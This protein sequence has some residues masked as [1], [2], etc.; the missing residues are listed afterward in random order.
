M[1]TQKNS[2]LLSAIKM[3]E[4]TLIDAMIFQEILAGID[5]NIPTLAFSTSQ[6][7]VKNSLSTVWAKILVDDYVP[8]FKIALDLLTVIPSSPGVEEA[9]KTLAVEAQKIAS[10]RALLRHDLMG[11]I[12]HRLLMSDIAKFYATYYTSVP[13][14]YLLA[15]FALDAPNDYWQF[16]WANLDSVANF[17]VAD[18]ACGSGTLL[19]AAYSAILDKYVIT[20]AGEDFE[21]DPKKLHRILIE[22][23]LLGLDVLSFAAHLSAVTLA[24]H[25]PSSEFGNTQIYAL[26]QTGKADKPRLG[27]IDL[28]ESSEITP[29]YL[30]S[31]SGIIGKV[32]SPEQ[33]GITQSGSLSIK[34]EPQN[35]ITMNPPFTRSVIGNKLFGALPANERKK[36]QSH[37][38]KLLKQKGFSGIGQAGLAAVFV[39]IGDKYLQQGGR[40]AF[41][42]P[43]SLMSGVSWRKIRELLVENYEIE[44]IITSHEAPDGWNFSENTYLSEI[45]LVARKLT[46]EKPSKTIIVNLWKKPVNEMEAIVVSGSLVGLS[47]LTVSQSNVHDLLE[48]ANATPFPITLGQKQ[49]GEAYVV[50]SAV[51]VDTLDTWGQVAPF[52]QGS[53]N[54]LAYSFMKSGYITNDQLYFPLT[55]LFDL[56]ATI[57]PDISQ[58]RGTFSTASMETSFKSLWNHDSKYIKKITL[59]PNMY[60]QPKAGN[61]QKADA[62]WSTGRGQLMVGS[63]IRLNTHRVAAV[64]LSEEALA[65]MWWPVRLTD[66]LT[67]DGKTIYS[68]EHGKI[69]ALWLNST[70]GLLN[71]LSLRQD[72]EGPW[73][74]L[75]K[76]VLQIVPFLDIS[77]LTREQVEKLIAFYAVVANEELPPIPEQ[78]HL[79]VQKTGWRYKVDMMLLEIING[80][81]ADLTTIY[82]MLAREPILCLKPLV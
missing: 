43:R 27:S 40:L 79:S 20:S 11:R 80:N 8:I 16:N 50:S 71:I 10:S 30:S 57:G 44:L 82:D 9:L 60:L 62:L 29:S 13:S 34:I 4:L 19:S 56:K 15:R 74:Q 64:L 54:R 45:L 51:L 2:D 28:L 23:V 17:R 41:V 61:A 59:P 37:L 81:V 46:E 18:F 69:Q 1:K 35:L 72:T 52:A 33:K 65:S 12:Y 55:T 53:L 75:K 22:K 32:V 31:L 49:I 73:V 25:N 3:G 63:R 7:P 78:F 6:P 21:T 39:L 26:M 24:L 70:F 36:L 77:K 5:T 68:E 67:S 42:I 38:Q 48:N 14:A 47:K 76:E 66:V 58:V